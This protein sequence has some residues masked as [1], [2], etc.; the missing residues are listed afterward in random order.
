[1]DPIQPIA[2]RPPAVGPIGPARVERVTRERDRP[3][4]REEGKERD[5]EG[6]RAPADAERK[7]P[8]EDDQ[9]RHVDVRV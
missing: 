5:G 7:P 8:G 3:G 2:P 6:R 1:M 9:P 4:P